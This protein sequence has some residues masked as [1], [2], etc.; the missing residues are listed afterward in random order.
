MLALKLNFIYLYSYIHCRK[1]GQASRLACSN[2]TKF[3]KV[4]GQCVEIRPHYGE[5]VGN[6]LISQKHFPDYQNYLDICQTGGNGIKF[7]D[8]SDPSCHK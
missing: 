7:S 1:T 8:C 3:N 2:G 5:T 4:I 6:P